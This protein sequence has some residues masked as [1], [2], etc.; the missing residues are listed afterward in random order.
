MNLP[1]YYRDCYLPRLVAKG[2]AR[3]TI[4][5]YGLVVRLAPGEPTAESVTTW[6]ASMDS[7]PATRNKHRRYLLAILRDAR[8]RGLVD[9]WIED[10]PKAIETLTLPRAWRIDEFERLL[11][12]CDQ[13]D[14]KYTGIRADLWW[15]S[16]LLT[17]WYTGLRVHSLLDSRC[18]NLDLGAGT[19]VVASPKD[20]CQILYM[21]PDDACDAIRRI[22]WHRTHIWP[23]PFGDK[24]KTLLRRI[25]HLIALAEL[26]QL[27]RPFHAIRR[28]V[29]S[30][31]AATAGV[32]SA[33]EVLDH[34]RMEITR[35]YYIDPR[36][37]KPTKRAG[38]SM[39]RPQQTWLEAGK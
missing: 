38:Q 19:L 30:Y 22:H 27:S 36:I 35:R 25:R 10:V 16:F 13:L 24:T 17:L 4:E 32:A 31:V 26:P 7:P 33:C 37:A 28:S 15:Q 6:L 5:D 14:E 1:A 18:E 3:T 11:A 21:L 23:W 39:P 20:R 34:C 2:V 9:D 12:V 8:R 29:A